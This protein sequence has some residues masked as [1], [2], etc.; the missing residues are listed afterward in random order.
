M[1]AFRPYAASAG[2]SASGEACRP[3]E[4]TPNRADL[5]RTLVVQRG[6]ALGAISS[7]IFCTCGQGGIWRQWPSHWSGNRPSVSARRRRRGR[8]GHPFQENPPRLVARKATFA[9]APGARSAIRRA[10]RAHLFQTIT[11]PLCITDT[12]SEKFSACTG[13][14]RKPQSIESLM[15]CHVYNWENNQD[16]SVPLS[17]ETGEGGPRVSEG[18]VRAPRLGQSV[19]SWRDPSSV[20]PIGGRIPA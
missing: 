12:P 20:A 3:F 16:A 5:R 7:A 18:R 15:L 6:Q 9:G 1:G 17:R 4:T 2:S 8:D 19:A 11:R 10:G 13:L 14:S